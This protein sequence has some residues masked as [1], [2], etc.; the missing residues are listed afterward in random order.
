M[1]YSKILNWIFRIILL[2][3]VFLMIG[4]VGASDYAVE[5]GIYEPFTAHMKEFIFGMILVISGIIYLNIVEREDSQLSRYREEKPLE[6]EDKF[7]FEDS[8]IIQEL[9]KSDRLTEREK[10][11]LQRLYR[12]YQHMVD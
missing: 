7:L 5:F 2:I 12:T 10:L 3:G 4:A 11:A 8:E 9:R 1:N 6:N